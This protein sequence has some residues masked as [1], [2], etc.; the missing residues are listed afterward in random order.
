MEKVGQ[1][2]AFFVLRDRTV[3][4]VTA[5]TH[6]VVPFMKSVLSVKIQ[7][8]IWLVLV[9]AGGLLGLFTVVAVSSITW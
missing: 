2:P 7:T 8:L 4:S 3:F 5:Y 1:Y 6:P 9:I